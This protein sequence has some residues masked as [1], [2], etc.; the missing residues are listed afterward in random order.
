MGLV[1]ATGKELLQIASMPDRLGGGDAA[2]ASSWRMAT[3]SVYQYFK[4][5]RYIGIMT[6][7]IHSSLTHSS[8]YMKKGGLGV[9]R[10]EV[11]AGGEIGPDGCRWH[12]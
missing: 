1:E 2:D 3:K 9:V 6:G 11:H 5:Y 7:C 8:Q 12:G 4:G 10:G